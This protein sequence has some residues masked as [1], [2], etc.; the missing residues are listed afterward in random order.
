MK[1]TNQL[2]DAVNGGARVG[3]LILAVVAFAAIWETDAKRKDDWVAQ[4]NRT[5]TP[6]PIA[7]NGATDEN[8]N[9][10]A[11]TSERQKST[12]ITSVAAVESFKLEE[13]KLAERSNSST[14]G[15]QESQQRQIVSTAGD[16]L[17]SNLKLPESIAP[18]SYR[19][20]DTQGRV[21][22]IRLGSGESTQGPKMYSVESAG[23]TTYFIRIDGQADHIE[24]S[25]ETTRR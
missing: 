17:W 7:Y 4:Q 16:S 11:I 24:A 13:S 6:L 14:V 3:A 12:T 9:L 19:I 21:D 23:V 18:G 15:Q 10:A 5:F 22:F 8:E 25:V 20:V 2:A 1:S